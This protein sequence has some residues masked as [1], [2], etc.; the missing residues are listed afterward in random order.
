[1]LPLKAST[2]V[3]PPKKVGQYK[4]LYFGWLYFPGQGGILSHQKCDALFPPKEVVGVAAE[5]C[6]GH[7]TRSKRLQGGAAQCFDILDI[8]VTVSSVVETG[9]TSLLWTLNGFGVYK[10][11]ML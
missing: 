10:F 6:Q 5:P 4:Y 7:V 9:M 8:Y 2:N 1:M 3:L 11:E